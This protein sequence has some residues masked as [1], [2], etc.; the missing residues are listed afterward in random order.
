M[1][2]R[3]ELLIIAG[4]LG[5]EDKEIPIDSESCNIQL[6][7]L[8]LSKL[9]PN[10]NMVLGREGQEIYQKVSDLPDSLAFPQNV[11]EGNKLSEFNYLWSELGNFQD[12]LKQDYTCRRKMLLTRLDCTIESFKWKG[13]DI[14]NKSKTSGDNATAHPSSLID[15]NK[16]SLNDLIH[17]KYQPRKDMRDEPQ[18][19]IS[20]LLALRATDCDKLL[21]CVV[22]SQTVD[23]K[24]DYKSQKQNQHRSQNEPEKLVNLKQII[25]PD[26]PDRG[27][28]T[29]EIRPPRKE[30]FSR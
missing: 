27:G 12:S 4:L 8:I 21:N 2:S 10:R 18:V 20:H 26:V 7:K 19:T 25:I 13:S 11:R 29:G 28:R 5:I 22:S 17:E 6:L 30:T 24:V 16:K 23:C 3:K 1:E 9:D 14:K 15:G